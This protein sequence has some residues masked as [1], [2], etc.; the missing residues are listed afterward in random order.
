VPD[1]MN[2]VLKYDNTKLC[3]KCGK[4]PA[5]KAHPCPFESD[6][7]DDKLFRCDCCESCQL[8]CDENR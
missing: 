7:N 5:L 2:A 4:N 1:V 3:K 8:E 6:I